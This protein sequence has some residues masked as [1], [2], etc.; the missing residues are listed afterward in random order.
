MLY[1]NICPREE[2]LN[3]NRQESET[4]SPL[5]GP[6]ICSQKLYSDNQNYGKY[7][8][9]DSLG[10]LAKPY[11]HT[12]LTHSVSSPLHSRVW[13]YSNQRTFHCDHVQQ[14]KWSKSVN[15]ARHNLFATRQKSLDSMPPTIFPGLDA[16]HVFRRLCSFHTGWSGCNTFLTP[17]EFNVQI[18]PA[19]PFD[20]GHATHN[21]LIDAQVSDWGHTVHKQ[22][23]I[24][25]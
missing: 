3:A 6:I 5:F 18:D 9:I 25:M 10:K 20:A 15:E 11:R 8:N 16:L 2:F 14:G 7:I 21:P 17:A 19:A 22:L 12:D 4:H 24:S 1:S 13:V 23:Y